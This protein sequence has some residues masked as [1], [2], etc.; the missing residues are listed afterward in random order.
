MA[1]GGLPVPEGRRLNRPPF[2]SARRLGRVLVGGSMIVAS[3]AFVTLTGSPGQAASPSLV[4]W[5]Q[6]NGSANGCTTACPAS[7]AARAAD[8]LSYDQATGEVMLFGGL[9]AGF[10][11][12]N[13]T[14]AWSGSTWS[15]V[16]DAT[17]PGC[18]VACV[19]SPPARSA[20]MMAY[21]A[22]SNQLILFG[23]QGGTY[24]NDTW[25]WN[26]TTWTQVA[27]GTDPGCTDTCAGSPSAR[28]GAVMAYDPSIGKLVLFGGITGTNDTWTWNGTAWAQ[29]ADA[30]D[31]GCTTACTGSPPASVAASMAYDL[32]ANQLILF[33]GGD[34][35]GNATWSFDG[36]T[37]SQLDDGTDAGCTDT[38]TSSPPPRSGSGMDYN[39]ALGQ[40]VLFGGLDGS[41][42]LNDTW[43]W[44]G[45]TWTQ[46]DD[47][48]D[49]GCTTTCPAS[50]PSRSAIFLTY[51]ETNRQSVLF[52][53][54][55]TPAYSAPVL[56]DTWV[57]LPAPAPPPA[58]IPRGYWL[59]ASDG[60]VFSYGA[61]FEGSHGS[62][63]L[64]APIVA[65]ASTPDGKGY[66]LVSADGGV[67][68][69]GDAGFYGSHGGSPLN[70]PIVG[71]AATRDGKGYWLVAS[72]GGVFNYGDATFYGS[73]GGSPLNK[74]VVGMASRPSGSGY[75]LVASDGGVFAYGDTT[76]YGSHGGV[77]L[78]QPVVGV[79][80]SP[81]GAGYWLVASDGG[82]FAYGDA[83]F[84]GSH[85]GSPLNEPIVGL[86]S[87]AD[88][89][90]YLMDASDGGVFAYGDAVFQGSHGGSPLNE[91][92]VGM[93]AE[94]GAQPG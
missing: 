15:Q 60:G 92:I 49:P 90:G 94:G 50:P 25:A 59:V 44:N 53:G 33:G 6:A 45:T 34:Y 78:N 7:P 19:G 77:P 14:W 23:G 69:Y 37:W 30:T 66:W 52:G 89:K 80:A 43:T 31:S 32:A 58:P 21:D 39:P 16:A 56:E 51:D 8:A 82:V 57:S 85:G 72:D 5:T 38:C 70:K 18:T 73:H 87:T 1:R 27:D 62:S 93:A 81:S 47:D 65:M 74:P 68:T 71:M 46:V 20:S 17:D 41:T 88:G 22:A 91:P 35:N 11:N 55:G 36:T 12:L 54:Q 76:F 61:P 84:Y 2:G 64:N 26:G 4:A 63:P 28:T 79:A 40:L 29:V 9:G 42:N 3:L 83:T 48:T 24:L 86:A 13:D 67:F 10:T 75:W